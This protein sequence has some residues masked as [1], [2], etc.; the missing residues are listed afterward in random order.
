MKKNKDK[1][2]K[3]QDPTQIHHHLI[4]I[5]K[6]LSLCYDTYPSRDNHGYV[7][8]LYDEKHRVYDIYGIIYRDNT[9]GSPLL[10]TS[11]FIK[12]L[13]L[14]SFFTF[15]KVTLLKSHFLR[16]SADSFRPL[17]RS[18]IAILVTMI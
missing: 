9:I 1:R 13:L 6:M 2:G 5:S 7:L 4:M 16:Y 15:I 14:F 8:H 12:R 18:D 10:A 11:H 17:S 3:K